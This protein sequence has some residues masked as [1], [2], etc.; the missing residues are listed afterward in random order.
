VEQY[1]EDAN[2]LWKNTKR[3]FT[4]HINQGQIYL[5]LAHLMFGDEAPKDIVFIYEF[6][7]NQQIKEFVVPYNPDLTKGIFRDAADIVR[8]IEKNAGPPECVTGHSCS[9]CSAYAE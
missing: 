4:S 7:V 8:R 2:L 5:H 9:E 6:K 3:P 1:G